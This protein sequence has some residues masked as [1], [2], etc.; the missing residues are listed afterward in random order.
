MSSVEPFYITQAAHDRLVRQLAEA[1]VQVP[2][3]ASAKADAAALGD[4]SEN[5]EYKDAKAALSRLNTRILSIQDRLRRAV[6]IQGQMYT[7]E[8]EGKPETRKTYEVV[9]AFEADP[10][11]GRIS[12]ESPLGK[13]LI[14]REAG[15]LVQ[16]KNPTAT[17]SY[18]IV[19]APPNS[20]SA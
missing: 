2:K 3:L 9:G 1:Q 18:R 6:I 11:R 19:S 12:N 5:A 16:I 14:G 20:S 15:D 13:M 7:V 10:A 4:R 8:V 17:V